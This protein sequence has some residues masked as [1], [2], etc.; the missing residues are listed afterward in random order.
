MKKDRTSLQVLHL[1]G[2]PRTEVTLLGTLLD[3]EEPPT[4]RRDEDQEVEVQPS[5]RT[6]VFK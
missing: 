3:L 4:Q 1:T 5:P 6:V 2:L